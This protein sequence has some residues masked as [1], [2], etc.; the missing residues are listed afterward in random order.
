M[1]QLMP[2][3]IFVIGAHI[4]FQVVLTAT[5]HAVDH[6]A[7]VIAAP[8]EQPFPG[9]GQQ[10]RVHRVA[11]SGLPGRYIIRPAFEEDGAKPV[12]TD[13]PQDDLL[14]VNSVPPLEWVINPT[15]RGFTIFNDKEQY[16]TAEH[17]GAQIRLG[18]PNGSPNQTWTLRFLAPAAG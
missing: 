4:G 5:P 12:L 1:S 14:W 7:P 13:N 17:I 6:G 18:K 15:P 16:L 11:D 3:G 9:P 2:D 8:Q 10:W